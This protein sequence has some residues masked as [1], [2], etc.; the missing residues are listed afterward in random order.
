MTAFNDLNGVPCTGNQ[1][2]FK[3]ILRDRWGFG[4]MVVTDYTAI[5]EMVA[6]GFAKDLKHA[7]E[8][9]IDAGIDMDMISEAL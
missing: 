5:M 2:L 7:A 1:Y 9:A 8:L 4:G 3:E 6:H